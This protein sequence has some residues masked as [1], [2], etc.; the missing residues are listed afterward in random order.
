MSDYDVVAVIV[1]KGEKIWTMSLGRWIRDQ[2]RETK[3]QRKF[4]SE[5]LRAL[6][7]E[8]SVYIGGTPDGRFNRY[9]ILETV[10]ELSPKDER[11]NVIEY[12]SFD[13][14]YEL[15]KSSLR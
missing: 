1:Q 11:G 14:A 15:V 7:K 12:V 8:H 5:R 3:K 2:E 13:K 4:L 6:S 9:L 10:Q